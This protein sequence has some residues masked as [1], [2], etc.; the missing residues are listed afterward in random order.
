M[1]NCPNCV[2]KI[3]E[4]FNF[5]PHCG[6]N[7]V[8]LKCPNCSIENEVRS[9]FCTQCGTELQINSKIKKTS[10]VDIN[11]YPIPDYGITV[12]FSYSSSQTFDFAVEEARKLN[13][14]QQIGEDKKAIYRV[15]VNED[16]IE[17]LEPLVDNLKGW[18]N[19]KVYH[20]G[21]KVLWDSIF[22]YQWCHD[23]KKNSFK[24]E[25]YCFGFENNYDFN[26]WGCV[27]TRLPF[28]KYS[29]IWTYGKWLN[30]KG[31]WEFD[32]ERIKHELE[33]NIYKFQ[34]CPSLNLDLIIDVINIFPEVVNP[35]KDEN[36]EFVKNYGSQEGLKITEKSSF[37]YAD[38]YYAKGAEP[39]SMKK[40]L[41]N[42]SSRLKMKVPE[43][44]IKEDY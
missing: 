28:T 18:R 22:N 3:D 8:V 27:Q 42:L 9:K 2:T 13:L 41:I 4:S 30:T 44:A 36:W 7:Q 40:F 5:C 17:R 20:N 37:G 16:E 14:F 24:P 34:F 10:K 26:L 1:K 19:R 11:E 43:G 12:E 31:D 39:K 21:S 25:L 35:A 29:Q 33:K 32:K 23:R 38:E 15:H 6:F